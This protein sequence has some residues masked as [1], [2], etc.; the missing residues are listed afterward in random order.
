MGRPYRARVA[1]ERLF[2]YADAHHG[3]LFPGPTL[4]C[5]DRLTGITVW[6]E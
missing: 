6:W 3:D 1:P 5:S 2:N 4:K